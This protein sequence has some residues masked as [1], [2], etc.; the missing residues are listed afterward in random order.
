MATFKSSR[1]KKRA[2][3]F[4]SKCT[5]VLSIVQEWVILKPIN[6]LRTNKSPKNGEIKDIVV[7]KYCSREILR[8]TDMINRKG[9]LKL[10]CY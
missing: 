4:L 8:Y 6:S 7:N 5:F 2:D 3:G 1:K 10:F 9:C